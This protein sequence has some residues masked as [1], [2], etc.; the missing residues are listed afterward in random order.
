MAWVVTPDCLGH[1]FCKKVK[2]MN[3]NELRDKIHEQAKQSGFY[4]NPVETGT[5]LML[6][7]SELTEALEADRVK[8]FTKPDTAFIEKLAEEKDY[9]GRCLFIDHFEKSL[10]DTFEDEIADTMIRI[11]DLC[12][13]MGIDIEKHVVLKMRYNSLRP[14]KH[15]KAY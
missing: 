12:G 13:Y 2:N 7:V 4:N 14:H 6:I 9:M 5:R 3:L 8:R 11:L 1:F 15:G 10:K